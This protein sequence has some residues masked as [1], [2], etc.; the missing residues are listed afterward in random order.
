[1]ILE[2]FEIKCLAQ[3]IS[4]I[5]FAILFIIVFSL[6]IILQLDS[7]FSFWI[8][9]V[10]SFFMSVIICSYIERKASE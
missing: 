6:C 10:V 3:V 1:M 4:L 5:S 7:K 8:S 2:P 9:F